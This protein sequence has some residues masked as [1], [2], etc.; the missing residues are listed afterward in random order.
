MNDWNYHI[1][2]WDWIVDLTEV[3]TVLTEGKMVVIEV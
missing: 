3:N 2:Y 1:D